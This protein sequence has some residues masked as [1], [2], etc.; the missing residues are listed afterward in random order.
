MEMYASQVFPAAGLSRLRSDY[1]NPTCGGNHQKS[2]SRGREPG[3]RLVNV[4]LA[5][6]AWPTSM[7]TMGLIVP[8]IWS[9]ASPSN[10]NVKTWAARI[11]GSNRKICILS[12]PDHATFLWRRGWPYS[13][14]RDPGHRL[15]VFCDKTMG[16]DGEPSE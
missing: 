12:W 1:A 2:Q 6:P 8:D 11:V 9:L 4:G 13:K 5:T 16:C 7:L 10:P 3:V 14:R 15:F